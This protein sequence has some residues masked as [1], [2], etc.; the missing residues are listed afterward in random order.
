[1]NNLMNL[2]WIEW[3]KAIRS[4][5]PQWTAIGSLFMPLGI[6]F[7]IFV[8]KN[9]EISKNLGLISAKADLLKYSAT[10]WPTYLGLAGQMVAAGGF[11]MFVI[12]VSWIF[13]REF[14]DGT[15]K[16]ML[17]VPI[18]R[19]TILVSKF[20]VSFLL[21]MIMTLVIAII[22][23]VMGL[24]IELPQASTDIILQGFFLVVITGLLVIPVVFPFALFASI[25]R[26]VLLPLGMAIL[27]LIMAN[28]IAVAGWGDFFPWCVPG[29][30]AMGSNLLPQLSYWIVVFTG[31]AGMVATYLWWM[32]A[33]QTQ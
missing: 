21:A 6:A 27:T 28:V 10:D 15:L 25:G 20:I 30:Y 32:Y 18:P 9:P 4:H 16:D 5:I 24:I 29:L 33:D 12:V 8:S 17:A 31:F 22:S 13:G 19:W 23:F 3:R 2:I 26:G 7:L 11:F 1:M 14:S